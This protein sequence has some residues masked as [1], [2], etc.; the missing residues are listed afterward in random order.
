MEVIRNP[1]GPLGDP[2]GPYTPRDPRLRGRRELPD[3]WDQYYPCRFQPP[4]RPGSPMSP[5]RRSAVTLDLR[6]SPCCHL[7]SP[8]PGLAF[9]PGPGVVDVPP[10]AGDDWRATAAP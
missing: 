6:L 8:R 1:A 9:S 3:R 4:C 5:N 10:A 7:A 2:R